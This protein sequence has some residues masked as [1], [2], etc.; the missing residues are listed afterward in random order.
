MFENSEGFQFLKTISKARNPFNFKLPEITQTKQPMGR[1]WV[2]TLK[3]LNEELKTYKGSDIQKALTSLPGLPWAKHSKEKHMPG[4]Q[5][6]GANTNLER[7]LNP[8]DT[9]KA[10]SIPVNRV[11]W[12]AYRHDLA[13][14]DNNDIQTRHAADKKMIQELEAIE[15]PTF[16]ER[17]ERMLIKKMLQAK[18]FLGQGVPKADRRSVSRKDR[19]FA[20]ERH[21]EFRRPKHLLKVK[22][23]GKDDIW[24][25]DLI[26]MPSERL[27]KYCLTVIDLYTRYAWV[28][29][30]KTKTALEV[31]K[32]FETIFKQSKRR[33]KKLWCDAGREFFN[34]EVKPLFNE[35]Y[36]TENAGKAVVVE[37]FN[38]TLKSKL[39][40][41]FTEQGNQKWLRILPKIVKEYNNKIH[42]SIGETPARAS[43]NPALIAIKTTDNNFENER[44]LKKQ[45]P[46]FEVG[47]RVRIFKLKNMF[48]KGYKGY[49][50]SEIFEV[51]EVLNTSPITYKI[52]DLDDE[53]IKGCFYANELQKTEL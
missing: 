28:V 9:P 27:Y 48:E 34:K 11:D 50:T 41:K 23:F 45:K 46:K 25:A 21:K 20:D 33:P 37:R 15:N 14:R 26:E 44:T 4:H 2:T 29:P 17:V 6:T 1:S 47:D 7:R 36:H 18:M 53:E 22:V 5:F 43:K 19:I 51:D 16:R 42:S 13:Y 31:K 30:L 35:V 40:K 32:A 8:D 10:D 38:R 24:S 39:F 49:W 52:K 3:E 12:A